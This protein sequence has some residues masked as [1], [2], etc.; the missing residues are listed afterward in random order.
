M[1]KIRWCGMI[2]AQIC[3]Q[4]PETLW[5][6]TRKHVIGLCNKIIDAR[7]KMKIVDAS[8]MHIQWTNAALMRKSNG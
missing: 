1:A 7:K 6:A 3:V 5:D 2:C 8:I 4:I